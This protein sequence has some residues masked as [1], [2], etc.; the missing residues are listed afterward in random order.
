[1]QKKSI[2]SKPAPPA[3][4]EAGQSLVELA[5]I[6]SL[7]LVLIAGAANFGRAFFTYL[8]LRDAAQEG[9][10]YGSIE[11]GDDEAIK[12]RAYANLAETG[13]IGTLG[14]PE[15]DLDID[16]QFFGPRC[17]GSVVQ[18]DISYPNFPL[19]IPFVGDIFNLNTINIHATVND[20]VLRPSVCP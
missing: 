13:P 16:V 20:T 4:N 10:S 5:I 8:S 12:D 19:S 15:A 6:F 7:L 2:S 3:S 11:P 1:M 9:A 17:L 18:V 14:I